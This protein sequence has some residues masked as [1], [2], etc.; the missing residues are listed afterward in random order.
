MIRTMHRWADLV[1]VAP[2]WRRT[3]ATVA[4][5]AVMASAV[6]VTTSNSPLPGVVALPG[7]TADPT[8]PT[9]PTGPGGNTGGGG[10]F[11]PPGAPQPGQDYGGGNY[12]APPQGNGIDINN[13]TAQPSSN[14]GTNQQ[15]GPTGRVP[16]HGTQ[17]PNYDLPAQQ[18]QPQVQQ[19]AEAQQEEPTGHQPEPPGSPDT[20]ESQQLRVLQ[21]H[22]E[23]ISQQLGITDAV[24]VL[25]ANLPSGDLQNGPG[26]I[27]G[28][29]VGACGVCP[30]QSPPQIGDQPQVPKKTITVRPRP[31]QEPRPETTDEADTDESPFPD[32]YCTPARNAG[33]SLCRNVVKVCFIKG[34]PEPAIGSEL[35]NERALYLSEANKLRKLNGGTLTRRSTKG[36][37]SRRNDETRAQRALHPDLYAGTGKVPGHMPDLTWAPDSAKLDLGR[38]ILPMDS[39]LNASIGPQA[40]RYPLG[41]VAEEFVGGTWVT[42]FSGAQTCM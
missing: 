22:C 31:R 4:I 2:V 23:Q 33:S 37:E 5:V 34:Q 41:F 14:P 20:P 12:P 17:P 16:V 25:P 19:P 13:P 28:G 10:Q 1:E 38:Q 30:P 40:L 27:V 9:G 42:D 18:P 35:W 36:L 29:G 24:M 26:R 7:A 32:D 15:T 21:E 6:T 39:S 3:M 8:G 11:Q